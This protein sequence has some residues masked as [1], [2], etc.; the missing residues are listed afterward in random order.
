MLLVVVLITTPKTTIDGCKYNRLLNGE[1]YLQPLRGLF[2]VIEATI[3][4]VN[5]MIQ[6][7]MFNVEFCCLMKSEV[8]Y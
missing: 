7:K 2:Y 1:W 5:I 4:K 8:I 6:E 3:M